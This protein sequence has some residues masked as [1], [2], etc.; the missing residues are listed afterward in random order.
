MQLE[1]T[2]A[3]AADAVV[4]T[5]S[6]SYEIQEMSLR[7]A[8]SKLDSALESSFAQMMMQ[9]RA[10]TIRM[11]TYHTQIQS[12]PAGNAEMSISL[13]RAFSRLNALFIHFQGSSAADTPPDN[14]QTTTSFLCPS[15]FAVGGVV[16]GVATHDEALLSWSMQLGSLLFPESPCTSIPETFSLLRHLRDP[17][18]VIEMCNI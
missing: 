12:L 8:V 16:N 7:C 1:L 17:G 2:L 15:A 13:V 11:N 4:S 10:L 14:K 9:N 5:S 3:D 6:T 18:D